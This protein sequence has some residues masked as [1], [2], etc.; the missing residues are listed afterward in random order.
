[1]SETESTGICVGRKVA[2]AFSTL[3]NVEAVALGGS[4]VGGCVDPDSDIDLYVYT[5]SAI[6]VGDRETIAAKLG[7]TKPEIGGAAFWDVADAWSDP[8]SGLKVEAVYWETSWIEKM[9]DRV[10]VKHRPGNGYSTSHWYTIRNSMCLYDKSGWFATLQERSRG[11]SPEEL[12]H[13]I[14]AWNHPVLG[15]ISES[16]RDQ[17]A[18]AVRRDDSVS[19]NHRLTELLASYFDIVFALNRALHPGEKR[20]LELAVEHCAKIP[21]NMRAQVEKVLRSASSDHQTLIGAID[22]LIDGLDHL[23]LEEGFDV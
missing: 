6:P 3:P 14:I 4:Q 18:M 10:L 16:Y 2:A 21:T 1:M 15:K 20:L 22:E 23:L 9:L 5:S 11:E 13:A 8:E 12:R 17:I 19:V 7:A